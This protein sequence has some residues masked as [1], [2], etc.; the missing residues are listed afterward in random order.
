MKLRNLLLV[1]IGAISLLLYY[2]SSNEKGLQVMS[3][4]IRYDNPDDGNNA[5]TNRKAMVFSFLNDQQPDII[6]FQE[7][8]KHQFVQLQEE[9]DNYHYVGAGRDD[10]KDKGEFV[11]IFYRNDK[12]ELLASSHFWLSET[13]EVFGSKSWGAA[14]PRIVTWV[15]L[16]D[17]EKGYIFYVFN[18][19]FSHVSNYARNESALLLLNKIK[20]I[21][22]EAPVLLTGDFNA[23]P[24]ERMY[25]TICDHWAGYV[26]MWDSRFLTVN[27]TDENH[28]TFNGFNPETKELCIDH[29]FV[30]AF[31]DVKNF[32]TSRVIED[33]VYL[34]DHYPIMSELNFRLKQRVNTSPTKKLIQSLAPPL[35]TNG[36]LVFKDSLAVSIKPQ[37]R[38]ATI[39]YT[40]DGSEPDTNSTQYHKQ[41]FVKQTCTIKARSFNE[42]MY[43]SKTSQQYLLRKTRLNPKLLEVIPSGDEEYSSPGYAALF[44]CLSGNMNNLKDGSWVGFNGTDVDF[45]FDFKSETKLSECHISFLS[46]PSKWIVSPSEIEVKASNDGINYTPIAQQTYSPSFNVSQVKQ[47]VC[48][49]SFKTRA[50][51]LKVSIYNGG[52]LPQAHS[53]RGNPSWLFM[54][55]IL[56]Q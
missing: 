25:K 23:P 43:P 36:Q 28:A 13:P 33:N 47:H 15:Q 27:K 48:T 45:T 50:R 41:I 9:L 19:H 2:C 8:L 46:D 40:L 30:N 17:L 32:S 26:P 49:L 54:D 29:I 16:K 21:A 42:G 24:S 6:G 12:Y 11:P 22:G 10:G 20:T 38:N 55:E 31:F 37:G 3:F 5:W 35:I 1:V 56:V 4:N 34:S 14:L 53:G 18:T 44:D 51:Y 39:H 7:V 52:L